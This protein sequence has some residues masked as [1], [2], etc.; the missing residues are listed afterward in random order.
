MN[1]QLS[2]AIAAINRRIVGIPFTCRIEGDW[3]LLR[4]DGEE[5]RFRTVVLENENADYWLDTFARSLIV[6][7]CLRR[8][9]RPVVD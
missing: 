9:F 3:V 4:V 6:K 7:V 2:A 5:V 8:H 1:K